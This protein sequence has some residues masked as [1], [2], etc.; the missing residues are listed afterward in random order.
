MPAA[1]DFFEES[2]THQHVRTCS[3]TSCSTGRTDTSRRLPR[4]TRFTSL[5]ARHESQLICS[6]MPASLMS[7]NLPIT[8]TE[9]DHTYTELADCG[10]PSLRHI[11]A[12]L[13]DATLGHVMA[14]MGIHKSCDGRVEPSLREL[15]RRTYFCFSPKTPLTMNMAHEREVWH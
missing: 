5:E 7:A 10:R 2:H 9:N 13:G 11:R 1:V 12:T 8:S 6:D 14:R 3:G 15:Q 4:F